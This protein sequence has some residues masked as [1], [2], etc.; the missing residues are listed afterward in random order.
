MIRYSGFTIDI[1]ETTASNWHFPQENAALY[2][3]C[4]GA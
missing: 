1:P 2:N 3:A 4:Q